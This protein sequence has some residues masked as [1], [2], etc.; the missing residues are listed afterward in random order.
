[1]AKNIVT[2]YIDDTSIRILVTQGK[3]IID[4]VDSPLEP[5]LVKNGL[6]LKEADIVAKIQQLFKDKKINKGNVLLG[7]SGS[8][9]L[10]RLLC[11]PDTAQR[12]AGGS[13]NSRSQKVATTAY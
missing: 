12:D 4:W 1:M 7:M 6:V 9:C 3:K 11:V 8:G 2:L 10:S 13:S 5:G